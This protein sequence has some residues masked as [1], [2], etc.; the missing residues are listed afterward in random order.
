MSRFTDTPAQLDARARA[1][2]ADLDRTRPRASRT[3]FDRRT[4]V[5]LHFGPACAARLYPALGAHPEAIEGRP[6]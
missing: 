6:A 3:D 2:V 4:V 5:S 1:V